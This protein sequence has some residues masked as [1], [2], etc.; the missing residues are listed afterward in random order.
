MV[1]LHSLP[2][3]SAYSVLNV[4]ILLVNPID[5]KGYLAYLLHNVFFQP[6]FWAAGYVC[7]I[8][9]VPHSGKPY[10]LER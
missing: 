3:P 2:E 7:R 9:A 6:E 10:T 1:M 8:S 5:D 4:I